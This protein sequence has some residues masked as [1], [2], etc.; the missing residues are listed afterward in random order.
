M[1]KW[2]QIQIKLFKP[3]HATMIIIQPSWRWNF[4]ERKEGCWD[5]Y[6]QIWNSY[7]S[8]TNKH[9]N[10]G[11][12]TLKKINSKVIYFNCL[13]QQ[14]PHYIETKINN[15]N[16]QRRRQTKGRCK[17]YRPVT[18]LPCIFKVCEK[19]LLSIAAY[20]ISYRFS[21][22]SSTRLLEKFR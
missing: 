22:L 15:P 18:L 1:G 13:L 5:K 11:G 20:S 19:I 6:F 14:N 10:Q 2:G 7:D 4:D 3:F 21:T 17:S 16:M 9:I 8:V 12:E